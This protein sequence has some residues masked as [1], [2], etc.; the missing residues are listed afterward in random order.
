M[1][2]GRRSG[3]RSRIDV[4]GSTRGL[5]RPFWALRIVGALGAAHI[6]KPPLGHRQV[7]FSL[8]PLSSSSYTMGVLDV[9]PV[10][11]CHPA[12]RFQPDSLRPRPACSPVKTFASFSNMQRNTKYVCIH[13]YTTRRSLLFVGCQFAIPVRAF[14]MIVILT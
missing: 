6:L 7:R 11:L 13:I 2:M 8:H 14:W 12:P 5:F 4:T 1:A 10:R 9:V 3:M